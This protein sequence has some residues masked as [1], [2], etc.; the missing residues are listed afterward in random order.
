[1]E[2]VTLLG[3]NIE[4]RIRS[5]GVE[6]GIVVAD[7]LARSDGFG[8][9]AL[10]RGTGPRDRHQDRLIVYVSG[11]DIAVAGKWLRTARL[12]LSL[13]RRPKKPYRSKVSISSAKAPITSM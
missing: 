4:G 2:P 7:R 11:G 6:K 9:E 3:R 5:A 8:Q 13:A 10:D 1:M 12:M